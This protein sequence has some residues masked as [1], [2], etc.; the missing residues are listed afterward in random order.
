LLA[1]AVPAIALIAVVATRAIEGPTDSTVA[2][3]G[4]NAVGIKQF[5]FHPRKLTVAKGSTLKVTN[6]DN[7]VHTFSAKD[8]SFDTGELDGGKTATVALN[9]SGTFRFYCKIHNFMTG[10]LVVK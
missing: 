6:A 8:D 5:A 7:T 9:Q 4:A 1:L 2:R 3:A 10:T